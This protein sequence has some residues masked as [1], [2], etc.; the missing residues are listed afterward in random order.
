MELIGKLIMGIFVARHAN[1]L[2]TIQLVEF[3]TVLEFH[4]EKIM[5]E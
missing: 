4:T 5:L 2:H 3:I 1:E